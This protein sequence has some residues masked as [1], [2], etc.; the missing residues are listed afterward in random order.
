MEFDT[1]TSD[2]LVLQQQCLRLPRGE[3]NDCPAKQTYPYREFEAEKG[4]Y[5][6]FH[7]AKRPIVAEHGG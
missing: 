7:V 2:A 6:H 5:I 1:C 4:T 3:A